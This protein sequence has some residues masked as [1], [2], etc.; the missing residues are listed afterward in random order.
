MNLV[1]PSFDN[2]ITTLGELFAALLNTNR[3]RAPNAVSSALAT[4]LTVIYSLLAIICASI[5]QAESG[6]QTSVVLSLLLGLVIFCMVLCLLFL[7]L[8]PKTTQV[9]IILKNDRRESVREDI[10]PWGI[11]SLS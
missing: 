8:Q 4:W 7:S 2:E 3:D 5:L 10:W 11:S 6:L 9:I 1:K